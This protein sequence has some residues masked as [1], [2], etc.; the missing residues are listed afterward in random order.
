MNQTLPHTVA[1]MFSVRLIGKMYAAFC[2]RCSYR[3]NFMH[4]PVT[5]LTHARMARH[6]DY[7]HHFDNSVRH[8]GI[9]PPSIA[10]D[11]PES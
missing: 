11:G 7:H 8:D 1:H 4:F 3:V 6:V 9:T 10:Y 5:A 2:H